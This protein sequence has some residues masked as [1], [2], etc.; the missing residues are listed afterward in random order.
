[1][2]AVDPDLAVSK[3]VPMGSFVEKSYAAPR[4]YSWLASG[5]AAFS[6][7][8]TA[9]GLFGLLSYQVSSRTREIGVRMAVGASRSQVASLVL[10]RGFLLTALGLAGGLA[11]GAALGSPLLGFIAGALNVSPQ[12]ASAVLPS[13]TGALFTTALVMLLTALLACLLPARRAAGVQPTEALRAE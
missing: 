4:F 8:L 13:R 12:E 10:R 7:L 3:F 5:L 2:S 6:L 9:V 11:L 1:M